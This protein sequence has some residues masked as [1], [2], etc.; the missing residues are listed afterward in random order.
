MFDDS[1]GP[2]EHFSW[3]KF[4]VCGVEHSGSPAGDVGVGKD[5]C[6]VGPE[7]TAWSERKGHRL[8][9]SMVS[10]VFDRDIVVLVVGTGVY[11]RLK[12][13]KKVRQSIGESGIV[14]VI[15]EPTPVA[16]RI[17][18]ELYHGGGRVAL[19]AHGTC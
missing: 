5:I 14:Q 4:V 16:C 18:N 3:G 11:G 15:L 13:P 2:I 6:L 1:K 10:G 12:C 7:V 17:Y 19:L 9:R 8:K